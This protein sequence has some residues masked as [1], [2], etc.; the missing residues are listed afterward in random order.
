MTTTSCQELTAIHVCPVSALKLIWSLLSKVK[1]PSPPF[2]T[3]LYDSTSG[4]I[5]HEFETHLVGL[6]APAVRSLSTHT[7]SILGPGQPF[8]VL[9]CGKQHTLLRPVNPLS[10]IHLESRSASSNGSPRSSLRAKHPCP[11]PS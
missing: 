6:A 5:N 9:P 1:T 4:R 3:D 2:E 7:A 10:L 8:P 11:P